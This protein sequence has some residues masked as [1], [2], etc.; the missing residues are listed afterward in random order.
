MFLLRCNSGYGWEWVGDHIRPRVRV[1]EKWHWPVGVSL[2][3]EVGYQRRQY[4]TDTWTW[5]MRPIVDQKSQAV[6]L[7]LQSDV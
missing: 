1:P 4:S 2:S 7:V 3:N 6:V 5:E